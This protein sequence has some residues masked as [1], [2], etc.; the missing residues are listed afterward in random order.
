MF[1]RWLGTSRVIQS[2]MRI[3]LL[4]LPVCIEIARKTI[5]L[6]ALGLYKLVSIVLLQLFSSKPA[7]NLTSLWLTSQSWA[8]ESNLMAQPFD[9]R[10]WKGSNCIQRIL[11]LVLLSMCTTRN[12]YHYKSLS[13]LQNTKA[14][15]LGQSSSQNR[16][17]EFRI[18]Y[19]RKLS[20]HLVYPRRIY[21]ELLVMAEVRIDRRLLQ[22]LCKG[23]PLEFESPVKNIV[24]FNFEL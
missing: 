12:T 22:L 2:R 9:T 14:Q 5:R 17:G 20:I 7:P 8:W 18:L 4:D 19:S 13:S 21:T 6:M 24:C 11:Q 10:I 3:W 23:F 15:L 1:Q 16:E